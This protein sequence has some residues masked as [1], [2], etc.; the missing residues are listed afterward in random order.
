MTDQPIGTCTMIL[1]QDQTKILLGK[2]INCYMAGWWGLPGGRVELGEKLA[3]SAQREVEEE[4]GIKVVMMQWIGVVKEFQQQKD[5]IHFG[6]KCLEYQ[7]EIKT[8][9]KDKCEGW[10][11]YEINNLPSQI[12][13]GHKAVIDMFINSNGIKLSDI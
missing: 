7:G 10:Q 1:N 6:F 12:I 4:T 13:P 11:W 3:V 9:E 5:F 8:M 2:R